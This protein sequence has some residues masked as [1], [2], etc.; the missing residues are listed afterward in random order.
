[1]AFFDVGDTVVADQSAQRLVAG[2][3]Y[4]VVAVDVQATPF[5]EFVTYTLR[6]SNRS[7]L[8]VRNAHL[9]VSRVCRACH[10][11]RATRVV[12]RGHGPELCAACERSVD[13]EPRMDR[14][15]R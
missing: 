13:L 4:A 1:M 15:A 2:E 6:H 11:D 9:L 3:L 5:G 7:K 12:R 14:E 10:E 8:Q